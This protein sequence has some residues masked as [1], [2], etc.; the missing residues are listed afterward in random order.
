MSDSHQKEIRS[1]VNLWSLTILTAAQFLCQCRSASFRKVGRLQCKIRN[2]VR[3][4]FWLLWAPGGKHRLQ[5]GGDFRLATAGADIRI[6]YI[7]YIHT[8][9]IMYEYSTVRIFNTLYIYIDGNSP[10]ITINK[11]E[12]LKMNLG[13]SFERGYD[14]LCIWMCYMIYVC[15]CIYIEVCVQMHNTYNM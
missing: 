10:A 12:F 11:H 8:C 1:L 6:L 9:L 5:R 14:D 7:Y 3:L 2:D 15:V 13:S 4:G